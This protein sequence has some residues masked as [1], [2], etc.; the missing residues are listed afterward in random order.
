MSLQTWRGKMRPRPSLLGLN[1]F[2]FCAKDQL[3]L[4]LMQTKNTKHFYLLSSICYC[5]FFSNVWKT[6]AWITLS[7]K[8]LTQS[9]SMHNIPLSVAGKYTCIATASEN[10]ESNHVN[11]LVT[12]VKAGFQIRQAQR[13]VNYSKKKNSLN[14]NRKFGSDRYLCV[15]ENSW[16]YLRKL[17][18]TPSNESR[19]DRNAAVWLVVTKPSARAADRTML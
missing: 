5:F 16:L 9:Y 11:F 17:F 3:V 15:K 12:D 10:A 6:L 13:I 7:F 1:Q 18:R 14:R 19:S 4:W 2:Y 8:N